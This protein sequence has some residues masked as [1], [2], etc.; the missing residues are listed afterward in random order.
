MQQEIRGKIVLITGASRGIGEATARAFAEAGAKLALFARSGALVKKLA[1]ELGNGSIGI[2][3]D[4]TDEKKVN[5]AVA[6]VIDAFGHIDILINNAGA[7]ADATL[8]ELDLETW[9]HILTANATSAFLMCKAVLPGMTERKAGRIINMSST[10]G[11]RGYAAQT[12]YC[13]AKH[14]LLGMGRALALEV[15]KDNIHVHNLCPGGVGTEFFKG[16]RL[17]ERLDGQVMLEAE[18]LADLCIFLCRLPENVDMTEV[19][20]TRFAP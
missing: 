1:E 3:C 10:T 17:A 14:A 8:M 20:L 16:T 12:A 2:A 18:N 6:E 9:N 19:S 5:A 7:F 15:K 13:A 4:V 11:I